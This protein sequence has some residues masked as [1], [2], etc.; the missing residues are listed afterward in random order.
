MFMSDFTRMYESFELWLAHETDMKLESRKAYLRY[1]HEFFMWIRQE[2]PGASLEVNRNHVAAYYKSQ[3][4]IGKS[5][6]TIRSSFFALR[7]FDRFLSSV[8]LGHVSFIDSKAP[9][10]Q[11]S[12]L[13]KILTK[14]QMND[15][16]MLPDISTH[17]G[18]RDSSILSVFCNTGIRVSEL[19]SLNLADVNLDEMTLCVRG[20]FGKQRMVLFKAH[21]RYL[22]QSWI[23]AR[24]NYNAAS[25][26]LFV[27]YR[28]R[29]LS[30]ST[31][32][33]IV[34]KYGELLPVNFP[35]G[36][37]T[38][39][40]SFATELLNHTGNLRAVQELLGHASIHT[41]QRY[42][43]VATERIHQVHNELHPRS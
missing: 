11:G 15:L 1:V 24:V 40:H 33:E 25:P 21:C 43:Q 23:L 13:P 2:F 39:R 37:H 6:G 14:A 10:K 41:T 42:T 8:L 27:S 36:P 32:H 22:L 19:C 17:E 28:G 38:L 5:K 29:R 30:R 12:A 16:E 7:C 35:I 9:T 26:A 34:S 3:R 20:K 31:V 18:L 4:S